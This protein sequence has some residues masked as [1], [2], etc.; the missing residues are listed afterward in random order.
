MIYFTSSIMCMIAFMLMPKYKEKKNLWRALIMTGMAYECYVCM[1][2][3]IMTIIHIPVNM[4]AISIMNVLCTGAIIIRIV[5]CH[6]IQR[7]NIKISDTIF[8]IALSVAIA[9][10]VVDRFGLNLNIVFQAADP[11]AHLKTAMDFVHKEAVGGMYISQLM[12]GLM[13]EALGNVFTNELVYKPFI[14]QYGINFFMAAAVFWAVIEKYGDRLVLRLLGYVITLA[15]VL[16]YPYNDMLYGFTYLQMGITVICYMIALVQDYIDGEVDTWFW[17]V[18]LSMG[19]L[20]SSIGYTLFAPPVYISVLAC[21]IYKEH[22]EKMLQKKFIW[23]ILEVFTLPAMITIWVIL[24]APRIGGT[25]VN[26]GTALGAEGGIYRNLYSDFLLYCVPAVYGLITVIK[27][28]MTSLCTFLVPIF[29][30]YYLFFGILMLKD[31]VST[32]YFYKLN[33]LL[34]MLILVMFMIGMHELIEN[35]KLMFGTVLGGILSLML[36]YASG[37]ELDYHN[38]NSNYLPYTDADTFFRVYSYNRE[39]RSAPSQ[40]P[41]ELID[42]SKVVD[43]QYKDDTVTFIGY[44]ENLYWFD[45][46][47]DQRNQDI[48][49]VEVEKYEGILQEFYNGD[50]GDYAVV[51]KGYEYLIPYQEQIESRVVYENDYAYIIKR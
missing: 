36:I 35:E 10:I 38:E 17:G 43:E 44:W 39:F 42:I 11:S 21:M 40:R 37:K 30:V 33:Y 24:I 31:K 14:I 26:Y 2:A 20:G 19:C 29:S 18:L 5:K 28:K 8:I 41:D 25:A 6:K 7:Y 23:H 4:Y 27:K 48:A 13:I 47:T 15:Y 12:N 1:V 9:Y 3:G 34:W 16:G 32:Y 50:I 45:A 22:R 51:E 49:T 46:L